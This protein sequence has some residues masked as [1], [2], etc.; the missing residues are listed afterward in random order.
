MR[1]YRVADR[2]RADFTAVV[3]DLGLTS[4]QARVLLQL[5]EP[6]PMRALA[7]HLGCDASN[8]TGIAHRLTAAGLVE[9]V[10]GRD[11]RVKL[12]RLTAE[13]VRLRAQV[14][15]SVAAGATV[16]AKLDAAERA[17]LTQL[18]DKVLA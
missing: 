5:G 14:A 10:E 4:L 16:T 11:R 15:E 3:A 9:R 12:L 7:E 18:L 8:V 13:G 1:L 2:A 17:R 6:T